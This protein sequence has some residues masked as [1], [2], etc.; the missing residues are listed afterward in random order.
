M[1]KKRKFKITIEREVL[2]HET[3]LIEAENGTK[4][5]AEAHRQAAAMDWHG[6]PLD[7]SFNIIGSVEVPNG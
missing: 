5:W 2:Q 6:H 3:F 4:A 1:T 7:Q